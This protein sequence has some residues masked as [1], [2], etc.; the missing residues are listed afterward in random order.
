MQITRRNKLEIIGS[1]LSICKS[2]GASKTRIVY[3]ANLNFKNAG[4]YLAWMTSRGYLIKDNKIYKTTSSGQALLDNLED[5]TSMIN[6]E[7]D[8]CLGSTLREQ[9]LSQV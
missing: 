5:L 8:G 2:G 6:G 3:Q 4:M 7:L 9:R 1:I